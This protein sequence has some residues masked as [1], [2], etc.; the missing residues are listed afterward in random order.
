MREPGTGAKSGHLYRG[1]Q[2]NLGWDLWIAAYRLCPDCTRLHVLAL[3]VEIS[4]FSVT[5]TRGPFV[6]QVQRN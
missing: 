6:G 5:H 3:K 4:L 1:S 2:A